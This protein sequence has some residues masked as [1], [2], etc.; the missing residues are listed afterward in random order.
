MKTASVL[1]NGELVGT[2]CK[3][4]SKS[5]TLEKIYC[6]TSD[7]CFEQSLYDFVFRNRY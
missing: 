4:G 1:R 6:R 5:Y 2:L 7:Q 3:L